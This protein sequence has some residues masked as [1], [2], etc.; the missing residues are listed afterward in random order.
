AKR[1]KTERR[2]QIDKLKQEAVGFGDRV[3]PDRAR[4]PK[5]AGCEDAVLSLLLLYP[6]HRQLMSDPDVLLTEQDF[7]TEFSKKVYRYL[8]ECCSGPTLD[9]PEMNLRFTEEEIGRI[10]ELKVMRLDLTENGR[11]AFLES[12]TA[13]REAMR[14]HRNMT[15]GG[16][17][18]SDLDS[19]IRSLRKEDA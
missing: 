7:F 6:E 13:L 17:S 10:T 1:R 19:L 3:N 12:V 8:A 14:M 15:E 4:A 11:G 16:T 2:D 5:V 18:L 9:V